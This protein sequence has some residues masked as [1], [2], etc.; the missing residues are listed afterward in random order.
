MKPKKEK[1]SNRTNRI[2]KLKLLLREHIQYIAAL[3]LILIA[4]LILSKFKFLILE[5]FDILTKNLGELEVLELLVWGLLV[6]IVIYIICI[7]IYTSYKIFKRKPNWW[8]WGTIL[9]IIC[10]FYIGFVFID[11]EIGVKDLRF[12]RT[13]ESGK[14]IEVNCT[15]QS[16]NLLVEETIN[17]KI[18]PQLKNSSLNVIFT[19]NNGTSKKVD[20]R[21]LTFIAPSEVKYL[22]FEMNGADINNKTVYLSVGRPYKFLTEEEYEQNRK[23]FVGYMLALLGITLFSIPALAVNF[24]TLSKKSSNQT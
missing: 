12:L 19:F 15:S 18:Q 22:L 23:E 4:I 9:G 14:T 20:I 6:F 11:Y 21:N 7:I 3:I 5:P 16:G 2:S 10:L 8:V 17:C 1:K 24:K 13:D